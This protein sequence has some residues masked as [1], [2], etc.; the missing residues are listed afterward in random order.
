[1]CALRAIRRDALMRLGMREMTYGWNL[2]MQM[3]AARGGL[4]VLEMPVAYRRRRG[5]S[6]KISGTAIGTLKAG[7]RIAVTLL[8]VAL[9]RRR[10]TDR[11]AAEPARR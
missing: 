8:R 9:E 3:R 11:R 1:M 10:W 7:L 6:S 4:R 5:G 2:E